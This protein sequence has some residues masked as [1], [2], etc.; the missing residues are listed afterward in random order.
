MTRGPALASVGRLREAIVTLVGAVGVSS[1]YGLADV[2]LR[3]RVNL[4]FAAA[5]EDPQLAYRVARE[6]MELTRRLGMRGYAYYM[7]GNAAELAMRIGDWEWVLPELEEAVSATVN[8]FVARMRLAE[9]RGLQGVDVRDELKLMADRVAAMTELQAQGSVAEV[10]ALVSLSRG[11]FQAALDLARWAYARGMGP[12]AIAPQTATRAAAWLRDAPAVRDAL[13]A[14]DGQP[15][16]VP[17]AIRRE[18]EASLAAIEGRNAEALSLFTD[19]IRRWRDLGLAFEAAICTLNLLTM[20][21]ASDPES[22]ALAADAEALFE[23]LDTKP[24]QKLLDDAM[25]STPAVADPR[26]APNRVEEASVNAS[27]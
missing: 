7:I 5:G 11:D 22:R 12:D 10:Q 18:A 27:E 17:A 9:M 1:S 14:I 23:R 8:D 26:P 2:E 25:R 4:S 20:L 13:N 3:A 16:R 19:A 6:G 21:G 15:G 24:F